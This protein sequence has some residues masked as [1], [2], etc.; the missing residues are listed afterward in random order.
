MTAHATCLGAHEENHPP[1]VGTCLFGTLNLKGYPFSLSHKFCL[2]MECNNP[3]DRKREK[4]R[5]PYNNKSLYICMPILLLG[6]SPLCWRLCFV[7]INPKI[8]SR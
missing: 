1:R 8:D 6:F 4:E 7:S 2:D 5:M 3:K